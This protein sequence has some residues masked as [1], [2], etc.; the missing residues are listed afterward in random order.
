MERQK[1]RAKAKLKSSLVSWVE[2]PFETY[3]VY[4]FT[5][6]NVNL[7]VVKRIS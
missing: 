1:I 4:V 3:K 5:H 6:R 2:L 7:A